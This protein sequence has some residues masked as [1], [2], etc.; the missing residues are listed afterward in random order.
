MLRVT[1]F[2]VIFILLTNHARSDDWQDPA[3]ELTVK[4]GTII[5][6]MVDDIFMG[7]ITDGMSNLAISAKDKIAG[8]IP[9]KPEANAE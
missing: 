3:V 7:A 4:L 5:I 6:E 2:A 8:A 9:E 1:F